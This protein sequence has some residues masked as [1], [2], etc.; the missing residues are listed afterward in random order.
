MS[1]PRAPRANARAEQIEPNGAAQRPTSPQRERSLK[2]ATCPFFLRREGHEAP[3][4]RQEQ[5][6]GPSKLSQM[7][8]RRD[9]RALN[10]SGP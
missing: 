5:T 2:S 4:E 9:R 10:E 8:Q 7:G 3:Q 6:Q 1:P